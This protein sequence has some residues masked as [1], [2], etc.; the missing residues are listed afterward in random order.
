MERM[1]ASEVREGRMRTRR[2]HSRRALELESPG[3]WVHHSEAR[4]ALW[5]R[6]QER[7]ESSWHSNR[8][9]RIPSR[10][11]VGA[12]GWVVYCFASDNVRLFLSAV[13]QRWSD[14][15]KVKLGLKVGEHSITGWFSLSSSPTSAPNSFPHL[16]QS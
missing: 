9:S 15:S 1:L 5:L 2:L 6:Q 7:R 13:L 14:V 16:L 10:A 11:H 12:K 3:G 4:Y 8:T